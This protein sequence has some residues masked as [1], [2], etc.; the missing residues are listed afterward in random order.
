M[1]CKDGGA[2]GLMDLKIQNTNCEDG[3]ANRKMIIEWMPLWMH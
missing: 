1:Q 3:K 2:V